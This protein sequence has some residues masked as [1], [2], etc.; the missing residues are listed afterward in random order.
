MYKNSIKKVK[1]ITFE[2][3]KHLANKKC[4]YVQ[5]LQIRRSGPALPSKLPKIKNVSLK[6]WS[7]T[8]VVTVV[9]AMVVSK[10]RR[11]YQARMAI[12]KFDRNFV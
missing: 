6:L 8:S 3:T 5:A 10:V 12:S 2:T 4:F 1:I 9:S 7:E 11:D